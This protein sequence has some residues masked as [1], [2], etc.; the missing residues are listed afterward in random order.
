MS[1]TRHHTKINE[2]VRNKRK[3]LLAFKQKH[4][5]KLALDDWYIEVPISKDFMSRK[6]FK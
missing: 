2:A 6:V 3:R 1:R 4:L 5:N